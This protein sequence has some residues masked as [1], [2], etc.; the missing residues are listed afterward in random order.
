M[1]IFEIKVIPS[2]GRIGCTLDRSSMLKCALKSPAENNKA[3]EELIK[4]IARAVG[5]QQHQVHIMTGLTARKKRVAIGINITYAQLLHS[6]GITEQQ[7][8]ALS[9]DGRVI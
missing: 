3:N 5:A 1:L 6:L 8:Q 9:S 7:T 2:S 4:F